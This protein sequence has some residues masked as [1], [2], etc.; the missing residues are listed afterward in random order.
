MVADL[1][2]GLDIGSSTTKV[3]IKEA[4]AGNDNF[5][6]VDFEGFGQTG[7]TY[8]LPTTLCF[9]KQTNSYFVPKRNQEAN[10]EDIKYK[11]MRGDENAEIYLT[12]FVAWVIQYAKKYFIK[13]YSK[14]DTFRNR[15][16]R[17]SINMGIPSAVFND[18]GNTKWL[19][20]LENAC[21]MHVD[22]PISTNSLKRL[23]RPDIDLHIIPEI[24]ATVKS[25]VEQD[26]ANNDGLY[27]AIDIGAT[28]L[29]MCTFR[30]FDSAVGEDKYAF[31]RASIEPY[32]A[33]RYEN[34]QNKQEFLEGCGTQFRKVIWETYRDKTPNEKEWHDGL[35]VILCGGGSYVPEYKQ[36]LKDFD[37]ENLKGIAIQRFGNSEYKGI[38]FVKL[39][40]NHYVCE[41][42]VDQKR[43]LVAQGLS[44][45]YIDFDDIKRIYK[46]CETTDVPI[47]M[48]DNYM[49]HSYVTKDMC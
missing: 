10:Y 35:P 45:P 42:S 12:A 19:K 2:M 29:D 48:T 46:T 6:V 23:S 26:G 11:F 5:Y 21:K 7:A 40:D 17:W 30:I 36:L 22:E 33:I 28:T 13:K 41:R 43:L 44:Y 32:G 4:W 15:E 18:E 14:T 39:P 31:F 34:A 20:V 9:D 37:E 38:R 8:L 49:G 27:C 1:I 16:I 24:I 25:F 47:I 3:V